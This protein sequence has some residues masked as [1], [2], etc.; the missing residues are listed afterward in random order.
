MHCLTL[1]LG[2]HVWF[3]DI[4][5]LSREKSLFIDKNTNTEMKML[6]EMTIERAA[7]HQWFS[8]LVTPSQWQ[9]DWLHEGFATYLEYFATATVTYITFAYHM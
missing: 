7:A 1:A 5:L 3:T 2:L 9:F 8:G 4:C 6:M